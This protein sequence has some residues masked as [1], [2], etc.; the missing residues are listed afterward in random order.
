[1][2]HWLEIY[3]QYLITSNVAIDVSVTANRMQ[4]RHRYYS[5]MHMI[6]FFK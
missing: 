1:M 4:V 5:Y 2:K 6:I 3:V